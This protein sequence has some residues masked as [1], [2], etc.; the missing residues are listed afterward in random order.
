MREILTDNAE[1]AG[2]LT[3]LPTPAAAHASAGMAA[4]A[5]A[6]RSR[7]AP[8]AEPVPD[9]AMAELQADLAGSRRRK[10]VAIDDPTVTYRRWLSIDSRIKDGAIVGDEERNWHRSYEG[11]DEWRSMQE[12]FKDFGLQAR[13]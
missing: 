7:R 6:A 8:R 4:A 10:V 9:D 12:F 13:A 3:R 1:Q 11:S 5:A 2:K